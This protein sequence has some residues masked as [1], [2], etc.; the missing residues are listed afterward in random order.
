METGSQ[1]CERNHF[2][3]F[4]FILFE[5]FPM[6]IYLKIYILG[7]KIQESKNAKE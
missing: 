3:P 2:L 4:I 7:G 5:F 1:E 6:Y